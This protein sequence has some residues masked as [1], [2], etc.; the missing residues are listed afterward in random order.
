[1]FF[2]HS[3]LVYTFVHIEEN[4]HIEIY[5]NIGAEVPMKYLEQVIRKFEKAQNFFLRIELIKDNKQLDGHAHE[6]MIVWCN[7]IRESLAKIF[8]SLFFAGTEKIS[9]SE[10]SE[11]FDVENPKRGFLE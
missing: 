11:T 2:Y 7:Q 3:F 8:I 9:N 10:Q 5:S 6:L 1:M 4:A